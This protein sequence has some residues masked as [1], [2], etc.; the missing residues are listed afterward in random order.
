MGTGGRSSYP[1]LI[2]IANIKKSVR[3]KAWTSAFMCAAYLPI[4]KFFV[5]KETQGVLDKRLY[6]MAVDIVVQPLKRVAVQGQMMSD[7]CG[8]LRK[9]FTPLAAAIVDNPEQLL[10]S[11]IAS[12]NSPISVANFR[13]FGNATPCALRSGNMILNAIEALNSSVDP[14][15][16]PQYIKEAKKV[17]LNG[18]DLPFWRDWA[19]AN[20][21]NFLT[22]DALHQWHKMV[23]DHVL[24]W[25]RC[26]MG[27]NEIDF[28]LSIIHPRVGFRHFREGITK[29]K[30]VTGREQRDFQRL[31]VGIATGAVPNGVLRSIRALIDFIYRGQAPLHTD[32]S[33]SEMDRCLS[34]FH[35]DKGAILAAG[36]R[37]GKNGVLNHFE[38]P[39][40]E[41]LQHVTRSIRN[42]GTAEQWTSDTTERCHIDL[43][44]DFYRISNRRDH[45]PQMCRAMDR[46]EKVKIFDMV[47]AFRFSGVDIRAEVSR[48]ETTAAELDPHRAWVSQILKG[49][50]LVGFSPPTRNFFQE[51]TG[52]V[53]NM[54]S[55]AYHL[56]GRPHHKG[57][58]IGDISTAYNLPD[59]RPALGDFLSEHTAMR[60]H[61]RRRSPSN[62]A[63][64]FTSANVWTNVKLQLRSYHDHDLVMPAQNIQAVS[65]SDDWPHGRCDT[66]LFV[67][68]GNT[69]AAIDGLKGRLFFA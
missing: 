44:K 13:E 58:Q 45:E 68:S 29:L 26:I 16:F 10:I 24:R 67:P 27:D 48:S 37:R 34:G 40:L 5:D 17:K 57:I 31:I 43:V 56:N 9:C 21:A 23:Y 55:V 59:L 30:Q 11:G 38:I 41:L 47:L 18:V 7:P 19:F 53:I 36:G 69:D 51:D 63:L 39:K 32:S 22:P 46:L 66:V 15:D 14:W 25:L 6:H 3:M 64:P 65:P 35:T 20:P 42:L 52:S 12:K 50:Q 2:S 1:F 54:S 61:R 62:V 4:A 60:A 49:E 28:R 8:L 33:L